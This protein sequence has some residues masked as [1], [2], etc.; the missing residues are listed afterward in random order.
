M[1]RPNLEILWRAGGWLAL[2]SV[3]GL[4]VVLIMTSSFDAAAIL[5]FPFVVTWVAAP[6]VG[7]AAFVGASSTHTGAIAFLVAEVSLMVS[8]A[9]LIVRQLYLYPGPLSGV[10]FIPWPVAQWVVLGV[11]FLAA[12]L[13]GWRMRPDFLRD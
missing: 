9:W 6:I 10:V 1:G 3:A 4:T 11:V 12:L 2:A 5:A 8:T 13:F 7:A